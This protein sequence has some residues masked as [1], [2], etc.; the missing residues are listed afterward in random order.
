MNFKQSF[1]HTDLFFS[2]HQDEEFV[3]G[4]NRGGVGDAGGF[5]VKLGAAGERARVARVT[6]AVS[7]SMMSQ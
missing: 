6:P 1:V 7:G 4:P 2:F 3:L 5:E